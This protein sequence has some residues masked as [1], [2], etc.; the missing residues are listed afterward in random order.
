MFWLRKAGSR[1]EQLAGLELTAQLARA[2]VWQA[3]RFRTVV[4][5]PPDAELAMCIDLEGRQPRL[6]QAA[7]RHVRLRP[8]TVHTG[9]SAK[10]AD[11]SVRLHGRYEL[12]PDD[13]M[14]L[15]LHTLRQALHAEG[16]ARVVVAVPP[17]LGPGQIRRL[18]ELA[19]EVDLSLQGTVVSPL[20]VAAAP[21]AV[22][23]LTR[24]ATSTNPRAGGLANSL[25]PDPSSTSDSGERCALPV[26]ASGGLPAVVV[27]VDI[28][29]HALTAAAVQIDAT[30]ARLQAVCSWPNWS[31]YYWQERLIDMLADRCIRLCRYDPRDCPEAEQG[32]FDQLEGA[33]TAG[34]LGQ[35]TR[36]RL[37]T[38]HWYQDIP[39]LPSEWESWCTALARGSV[40]AIRRW[41]EQQLGNR[42]VRAV[43]LTAAAAR[44]PGLARQ[45]ALEMPHHTEVQRLTPE[46]V[47]EAAAC[48]V[49]RWLAAELPLAHL[50]TFIP[51]PRAGGQGRV[52]S[53]QS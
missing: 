7:L 30:A 19:E 38:R 3:D 49:P 29:S 20:A 18:E 53:P 13:A 41:L 48:L 21:Q 46:A 15:V 28:D 24:A 17:Y 22:Q 6:G 47:A 45:I 10:L 43:W 42:S 52:L 16:P 23:H 5:D 50:D 36:I 32:L 4:L 37:R 27:V 44:C 25:A 51:L 8:H 31:A 34:Q 14:R 26:P 2:V 35:P 39:V 9:F 1:S 11:P 12:H 33:L 40:A